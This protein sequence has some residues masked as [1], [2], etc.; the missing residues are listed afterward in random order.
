MND[1]RGGRRGRRNRRGSSKFTAAG[2]LASFCGSRRWHHRKSD[3]LLAGDILIDGGNSYYI[4]D[5]RRGKELSAQGITTWMG[6]SG[7][8]GLSGYQMIGGELQVG[9]LDPIFKT[10]G[11]AA[12]P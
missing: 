10:L 12:A 11:R 4:D 8:A 1:W 3:S 5:I 6:T 7:G 9:Y 2:H